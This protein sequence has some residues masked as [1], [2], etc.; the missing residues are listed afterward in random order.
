MTCARY[1]GTYRATRPSYR[2]TRPSYRAT[3]P[4]YRATRLS[5]RAT[6]LSYR[7][8]ST[9]CSR[10]VS[11]FALL[12][13]NMKEHTGNH[14]EKWNN[15]H[16]VQMHKAPKEVC[17]KPERSNDDECQPC[18]SAYPFHGIGVKV[19]NFSSSRNIVEC[20]SWREATAGCKRRFQ[21]T[22]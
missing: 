21:R 19:R 13:P 14:Q 4:S 16:Q 6:R 1:A 9:S 3:R 18:V 10:S 17:Q 8:T 11:A 22:E 15:Q 7:A 5:Y 2:A 20:D 12:H